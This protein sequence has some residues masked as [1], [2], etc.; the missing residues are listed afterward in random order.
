[1]NE[2]VS[3]PAASTSASPWRL[4]HEM[5][6]YYRCN[7][8]TITNL[9]QRRILPFVKIGR[10]VRFNVIECDL[11]MSKYKR[12]KAFSQF[13]LARQDVSRRQCRNIVLAVRRFAA[14]MP[15]LVHQRI[16]NAQ[17]ADAPKPEPFQDVFVDDPKAI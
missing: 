17:P 9:M 13:V 14:T 6:D 7:I 3:E 12:A 11:A 8:R 16:L 4:K 1:M 5:A 2:L 15:S 10:L